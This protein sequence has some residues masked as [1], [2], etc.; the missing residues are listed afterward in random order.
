MNCSYRSLWNDRT[1]TYVAVSENAT[2]QGKKVS[3]GTTA[4]GAGIH[5][6]LQTLALSVALSFAAQVQALPVGGV[7]AAGSASISAGATST[8]ITQTS[9][10]AVIN[11]QSFNIAA[12][13]SVQ[14]VQPSPTAVALNRVLGADP[15]SILGSLS[16]NG[17]VFLVNPNGILF[18]QGASVNVGG[19][20]ASTLN[21]AD[22]DFLAGN[23]KFS[24]AG[25]GTVLNQGTL[26]VDGGFIAL[27]G[28]N[29]S[30][31][32]VISAQLGSVALA[33]GSVMTLDVAG[34]G[35]LNIAVN[36]GAVNALVQNGGLIRADGGQVLLTTQAAGS[37]LQNAVNNTGVIQAQTLVTGKSGSIKLMGGMSTG[38]VN[39]G[40]TL[41]ASA[42][43]GGNGGFIDTSAAH[44][45]VANNTLVTTQ[46]A[47][48]QTGNWLI[49]P[50]DF[51]VAAGADIA[52]VTLSANLVTTS[53]TILSSSGLAGVNGDVNINE[54]VTWTA[55]GAPTTLTLN[56]VNDVNFNAAVTATKGSLVAT[57]GRDVLVKA[58]VT[59]I[60][61]TNGSITWTATRDININAPI[62]TT[63]GNFTA[64]C[65]RDINIT[66]A[67]TTTRGNVTLK[68]GSDGTGPAGLIGGTVFFAPATPK[69]AVT[70]PGAAVT[71][72]YT[73]TSYATPNNYAVNF[74]LTGGATLTQ[75]MLVFVQGVNKVYDG[76]IAATLAFKGTP[77]LGG[78]VTLV[79]GTAT[80]DSKD[81]AANIGITYTG[82]SL[83]GVDAGL[84]AL[85]VACVPG[86]ERTSATI[87]PRPMSILA[88][89]ASKVYGQTFTPATSAFTT[90]VAPI[91][92]ETVLSVT[93]TST[94]SPASASVAGSTYPIIPSTA[95]AN[96]A[97]LP[98]NYAITYLNGALTVTPAPLTVTANDASKTF[99]QT[100]VLPTTAF[101]SVGLLNGDTVTAVT[102][103]SPGT[104]A[105]AAVAGSPYVI[106]PS[107]AIGTYV[108]SNYTVNYVNG[109][110]TV[111]PVVVPPIILPP[112]VIPPVVLPPVVVPPVV[113]P[114]VVVP[115]VVVP[116]VVVPPV[117]F[118]PVVVPPEV[119]PPVE[120]TPP[121]EVPPVDVPPVAV[122]PVGV[123]PVT[124]VPFVIPP[125]MI[126]PPI[127]VLPP[128]VVPPVVIPPKV[129]EP[130][131]VPPVLVS[132]QSPLV[133][134]VAPRRARKQDRN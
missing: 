82:Y 97:F 70:G 121:M 32:S 124:V 110:L 25:T 119:V 7:V 67:M 127:V 64:C 8:T 79:P 133:S 10:S 81:V 36:E 69:Y 53:V 68:A 4:R 37:L 84:F 29:V 5:F 23:Y 24:G 103:T 72:D 92:G 104:V 86:I 27:L 3:S 54:A 134:E 35:L 45:K 55:S 11:W 22:S 49:D 62:T 98:G 125:P 18:G 30:N 61:T 59:G 85:W 26:N 31:Q 102:E 66:A 34:D 80:L 76:G 43:N 129:I 99:G 74:T 52:G 6:A 2:S 65:G 51:T 44:V 89:S 126:V 109:V 132:V 73:P 111:A 117:V 88:N 12:G 13:Q 118:L 75:H 41:D 40:G 128:A 77:T 93:E 56:A 60:T 115:P 95:L 116:P 21:I 47:Q 15:S 106:V 63:D 38:T 101:T 78:V 42:P 113:V 91:A 112:V 96:G 16:A 1:G 130:V 28:A 19:L 39:V 131:V 58:G 57:A 114:P 50:P 46:S 17:R 94:G 108:P 87:T 105:T 33:A 123:P 107:G 120:T 122:P 9:P 83:G 100:T 14:F 90:P 48:G 71:L 20:L